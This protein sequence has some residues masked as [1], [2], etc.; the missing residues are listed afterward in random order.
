[1]ECWK[2][3]FYRMREQLEM[4]N[5]LLQQMVDESINLLHLKN[6]HI[7]PANYGTIYF[8]KIEFFVVYTLD[9]KIAVSEFRTLT[10]TS[11]SNITPS[12]QYAHGDAFFANSGESQNYGSKSSIYR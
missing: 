4:S 3:R 11:A 7:G 1:M 10:H 2:R 8:H 9:N 12:L 6:S 5:H